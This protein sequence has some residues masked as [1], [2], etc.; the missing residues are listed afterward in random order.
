MW[1]GRKVLLAGLCCFLLVL[2]VFAVG[3][4]LETAE[5]AASGPRLSKR[6]RGS[7]PVLC[8]AFVSESGRPLRLA[9]AMAQVYRQ[10][11]ESPGVAWEAVLLDVGGSDGDVAA[12]H[13]TLVPP[14]V[15]L[16]PVEKK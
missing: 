6:Y 1:K 11:Q 8:A 13:P 5:D 2:R 9:R 15:L 14:V 3:V 16:R 7:T 10:L 12:L 4:S